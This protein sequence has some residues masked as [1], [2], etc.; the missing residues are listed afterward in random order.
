MTSTMQADAAVSVG[1]HEHAS[2]MS[3]HDAAM[4]QDS[5]TTKVPRGHGQPQLA[6]A[7]SVGSASSIENTNSPTASVAITNTTASESNGCGTATSCNYRGRDGFSAASD[8]VNMHARLKN[9]E[10]ITTKSEQKSA[11]DALKGVATT[12]AKRKY[13][14]K[15]K[16]TQDKATYDALIY[17]ISASAPV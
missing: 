6:A 7:G 1:V 16:R 5:A 9:G 17:N 12:N 8:P 2:K 3:A 11:P 14:K 13:S 10:D 4:Q 15:R